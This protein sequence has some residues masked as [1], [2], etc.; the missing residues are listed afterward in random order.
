MSDKKGYAGRIK[1]SGVQVVKAPF[2][3]ESK[4]GKSVTKK[5]SDLRTTGKGGK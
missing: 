5:G 3:N 1:N 2:E 4:R